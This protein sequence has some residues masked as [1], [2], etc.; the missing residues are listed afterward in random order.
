M[1]TEEQALLHLSTTLAGIVMG[2]VLRFQLA[3][4]ALRPQLGRRV[5]QASP[6]AR[7]DALAP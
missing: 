7:T 5:A 2:L 1:R 6:P 4:V 3:N